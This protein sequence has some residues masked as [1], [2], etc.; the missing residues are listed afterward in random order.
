MSESNKIQVMLHAT[1]GAYTVTT[2]L[3]AG[4]VFHICFMEL[5][6][7]VLVTNTL[8]CLFYLYESACLVVFFC[9]SQFVF[10]I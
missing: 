5:D 4:I 9:S 7:F 1:L 6:T 10:H 2:C 8:N 3:L